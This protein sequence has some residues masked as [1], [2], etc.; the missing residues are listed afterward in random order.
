[1]KYRTKFV[2]PCFNL[3]HFSG[4]EFMYTKELKM[5][6]LDGKYVNHFETIIFA[7]EDV[8]AEIAKDLECIPYYN[9]VDYRQDDS[10]VKKT[11]AL[12]N[13]E[14]YWFR[15]NKELINQLPNDS[16][17]FI[18]SFSIYST[19]QWLLLNKYILRKNHKLKIV[20]RYSERLLPNYLKK[21][22]R[23][24]CGKFG[25]RV[26][27]DVFT[28]SK[29]LKVE[30][31]QCCGRTFTV[32]PVMAETEVVSKEIAKEKAQTNKHIITYLGAA[33]FDKGFHLLPVVVEH[34][35]TTDSKATFLIQASVPGTA[36]LE[37]EC[38]IA[39]VELFEL[40]K[41]FPDRVKIIAE[42]VDQ[43]VY[44]KLIRD[45]SVLLLPYVGHSYKT[46]TSGI[47]IEATTNGIPC[48]VPSFTW[49]SAQL[50]KTG[51]GVE[52]T[53][54]ETKALISAIDEVLRNYRKYHSKA[55][56]NMEAEKLK[57]GAKAQLMCILEE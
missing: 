52:F 34:I 33:R 30:Y 8:S 17:I 49:L 28:D 35:C 21:I 10:L 48:I 41:R 53:I 37:K 15:Q 1:M 20:F 51:G 44:R 19:W 46:Q 45:A 6:L 9:H 39:L 14:Y 50:I 18:H 56:D 24:I 32:L 13:R 29:E 27:A 22:H 36:Y 47:L 57:H 2:M 5:A 54:N 16:I 4:H 43:T 7:R 55:I 3:H 40:Q 38:E 12:I 26:N 42:P 23:M 31:E 25:E 11:F